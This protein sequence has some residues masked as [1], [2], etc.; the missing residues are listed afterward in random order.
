MDYL[1]VGFANLSSGLY[2]FGANSLEDL[3]V[4]EILAFVDLETNEIQDGYCYQENHT[5]V[6]KKVWLLKKGY[7]TIKSFFGESEAKEEYNRIINELR[8]DNKVIDVK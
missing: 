5:Y 4:S 3:T 1:N 2:G 7:K 6:Y 8:K